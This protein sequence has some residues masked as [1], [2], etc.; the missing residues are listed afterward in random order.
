MIA[1]IDD[2]L[3]EWGGWQRQQTGHSGPSGCVT[4]HYG[5]RASHGKGLVVNRNPV[6]EKIDRLVCLMGDA[7]GSQ[8]KRIVVGKYIYQS[9]DRELAER[10]RC[11][12]DTIHRRLDGAHCWLHGAVTGQMAMKK[13][14]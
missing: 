10:E 13:A 8:Y 9:I 4:M 14:S 2:L 11:G 6:A 12:R 7:L 3:R 5:P 1:E